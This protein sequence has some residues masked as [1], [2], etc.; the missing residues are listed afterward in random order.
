MKSGRDGWTRRQTDRPTDKQAGKQADAD[1]QMQTWA[2]LRI[3]SARTVAKSYGIRLLGSV[4]T[5]VPSPAAPTSH[6]AHSFA[7]SCPLFPSPTQPVRTLLQT[8]LPLHTSLLDP[9]CLEPVSRHPVRTSS[10][11]ALSVQN[12]VIST[13]LACLDSIGWT[14]LPQPCV[15]GPVCT[16]SNLDPACLDPACLSGPY[17]FSPACRGPSVKSGNQLSPTSP[18]W[19]PPDVITTCI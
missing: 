15:P 19:P 2:V 18:P 10:G 13:A 5:V 8:C 1:R 9:V 12:L 17:L 16:L 4:R 3:P 6:P 11:Q 14:P 7:P